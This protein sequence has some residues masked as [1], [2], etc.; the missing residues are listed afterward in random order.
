MQ[1]RCR[2]ELKEWLDFTYGEREGL[3]Q[4][5]HAIGKLKQI[6]NGLAN[7]WSNPS[8]TTDEMNARWNV[9]SKTW[10]EAVPMAVSMNTWFGDK[11]LMQSV[12]ATC[13]SAGLPRAE[14]INQTYATYVQEF[15]VLHET[16]R[17]QQVEE[18]LRRSQ[19]DLRD[20]QNWATWNEYKLY[21]LA[22]SLI[23][24]V[25]LGLMMRMFRQ[26]NQSCRMC[27]SCCGDIGDTATTTKIVRKDG[28]VAISHK[29]SPGK[30]PSSI[31][32]ASAVAVVT[33]VGGTSSGSSSSSKGNT[34][35]RMQGLAEKISALQQRVPTRD[36]AAQV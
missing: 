23:G 13:R 22:F 7:M 8:A 24:L 21:I 30:A 15:N 19:S 27:A 31:P 1:D 5:Q 2:G 28:G 9:L 36:L 14:L 18:D 3:Y 26:V 4:E 34:A 16:L 35:A 33:E 17:R 20:V 29:A 12:Q 11:V 10:T 25:A 32:C 6:S